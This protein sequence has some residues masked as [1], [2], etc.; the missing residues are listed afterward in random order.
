MRARG[1]W[2]R[3]PRR[4]AQGANRRSRQKWHMLHRLGLA[5]AWE[6]GDRGE[7]V[8][9]LLRASVARG[10]LHARIRSFSGSRPSPALPSFFLRQTP[11][12]LP[13]NLIK[14]LP[15]QK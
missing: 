3:K 13:V 1:A 14:N 4:N 10:I 7:E 2:V 11:V 6:D 15:A 9:E 8:Q 5:C 12:C